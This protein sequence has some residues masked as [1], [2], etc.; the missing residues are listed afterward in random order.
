MIGVLTFFF[1]MLKN[2]FG[3]NAAMPKTNR[4]AKLL[5]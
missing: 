4:S 2:Q 1:K 5:T 3:Q